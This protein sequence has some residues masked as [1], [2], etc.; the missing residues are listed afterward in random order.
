MAITKEV[1]K[2]DIQEKLLNENNEF[3]KRSVNHDAD[4]VNRIV[5]IPQAGA[6]AAIALN[7]SSFPATAA[8][9]TDTVLQ[10]TVNSYSIDPTHILNFEE[11]QL[12]YQKRM[13]VMGGQISAIN[14]RM[15]LEAAY[16]WAISAVAGKVIR[17]TGSGGA[18]QPAG[19]TGT[20]KQLTV[21][22][23]RKAAEVMDIDNVPSYGRVAVL[24]TNMYYELFGIDALLRKDYGYGNSLPTGVINRLFGFDIYVRPEVVGYDNTDAANNN[25]TKK[26]VGA[27]YGTTDSFGCILYQQDMVAKAMSDVQIYYDAK[28]PLFY[29]DV[30]SAE[31]FMGSSKLRTDNKGLVAIAQA[32]V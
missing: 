26:A 3:I 30:I 31:V 12:S 15:G 32:N 11:T 20:R 10:Y 23:M 18:T 13:S 5:N 1:W 22:D 16:S 4:I 6:N 7:R 9:R 21:A 8:Q 17:T 28:N 29:G 25:G 27:A 2:K 19:T 24:Q 14:E